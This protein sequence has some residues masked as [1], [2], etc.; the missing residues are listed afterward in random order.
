MTYAWLLFDAD[1]T[2]FNFERAEMA[3]LERAFLG[4]G[5]AYLPGH[6]LAFREI[7]RELWLAVEQGRLTVAQVLVQRFERLLAAVG[8]TGD[9]PQMSALFLHGLAEGAQLN[10]G[11][12][13]T[14][15]AL[16]GR[17]RLGLATN[18]ARDVQR[19]RLAR[20]G[21]RDYF[22]AVVISEEA[23]AAKPSASFFDAA[24]SLMGQPDRRAVLMI[25]D[26]WAADI[27]GASA[28]GLDTCWYNPARLPR[29]ATVEGVPTWE[30]AD[31]REL[32][33]L[34]ENQYAR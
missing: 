24:F 28:F 8:Q 12:Q 4:C 10:D 30:I 21:L 14:L 18:G 34:L 5:L 9:P 7:Q 33:G 29:P 3:A 6:V 23:S 1:G 32:V 11:A 2:L 22:A 25:G 13:T 15:D 31:L 20:S 26:S 27:Q 17:F 19:P 16:R